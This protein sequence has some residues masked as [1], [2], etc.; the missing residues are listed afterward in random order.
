MRLMPEPLRVLLL[1]NYQPDRQESMQRFSAMLER[2]LTERDVQVRTVRPAVSMPGLTGSLGKWVGHVDKFSRFRAALPGMVSWADVVHVCDHSNAMYCGRVTGRPT[3]V[4]CHDLLAIRSALGEFPE[5]I[6]RWSGRRLQAMILHG[7]KHARAVACVSRATQADLARIAGIGPERSSVVPNGLNHPYCPLPASAVDACLALHGIPSR[8]RYLLHVGGN[9]WYKHR[10][11]VLRITA[12]LRRLPGHE[13][14]RLVL[15]GE[16]LNDPLRRLAVEEGLSA[17][18][19]ELPGISNDHLNAVYNGALGLVFPSLHE[20]F[21]WPVIEAQAAQCP[22]FISDR[23]PLPEIAGT[24]AIRFDPLMPDR[25]AAAIAAALPQRA[26]LAEAGV[27][28]AA[29][30]SADAMIEGY[31]SLYRTLLP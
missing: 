8:A 3:L 13:D 31:L 18:L 23:A 4:T 10:S 19:H 1:G 20:G 6:T 29:R 25:A 2:G 14:I 26:R 11:A 15:V 5:N 17:Y 30:Y 24:S 28:N 7:L 22:V 27:E 16:R 21:G 9:H 12:A